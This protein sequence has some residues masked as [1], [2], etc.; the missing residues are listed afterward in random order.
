MMRRSQDF[1][2]YQTYPNVLSAFE[3]EPAEGERLNIER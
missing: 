1:Q 2:T 3:L